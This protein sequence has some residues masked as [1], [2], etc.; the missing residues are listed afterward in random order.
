MRRPDVTS[1]PCNIRIRAMHILTTSSQENGF[2]RWSDAQRPGNDD[3]GGATPFAVTE[4][5]TDD[6]EAVEEPPERE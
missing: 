5:P 2:N 1:I 4:P 6:R 3:P